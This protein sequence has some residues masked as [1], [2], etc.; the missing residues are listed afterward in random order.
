VS[1]LDQLTGVIAVG[2]DGA[3]RPVRQD[4]SLE[5]ARFLKYS[6][7]AG[8]KFMIFAGYDVNKYKRSIRIDVLG[9]V[10]AWWI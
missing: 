5:N 4:F 7:P 10:L 1:L 6:S 3:H 2:L 9:P 8:K